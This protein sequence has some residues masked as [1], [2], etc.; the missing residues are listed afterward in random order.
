MNKLLQQMT[1]RFHTIEGAN[2]SHMTSTPSMID[3]NIKVDSNTWDYFQNL[4]EDARA[5]MARVL[6][7]YVENER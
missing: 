2:Q 3:L 4:D 1:S 6:K 5:M 7:D